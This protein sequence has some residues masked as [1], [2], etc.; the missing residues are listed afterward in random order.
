MNDDIKKPVSRKL[1]LLKT[2]FM[3]L[4]RCFINQ[5][6]IL[7]TTVEYSH[8]YGYKEFQKTGAVVLIVSITHIA[9]N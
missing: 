4:R 1:K 3:K 9:K 5:K 6:Y 8:R 7:T 2:Q